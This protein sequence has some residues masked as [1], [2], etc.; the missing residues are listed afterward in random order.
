MSQSEVVQ[1]L[2]KTSA[3]L[4]EP[5]SVISNDTSHDQLRTH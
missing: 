4:V 2:D 1:V 5:E 3:I